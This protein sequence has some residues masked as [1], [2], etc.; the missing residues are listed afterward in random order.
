MTILNTDSLEGLLK[1]SAIAIKPSTARKVSESAEEYRY[2]KV[3]GSYVGKWRNSFAPYLTEVMDELG[4]TT[5]DAVI[6]A[7]PARCGKSDIFFNYLTHIQKSDPSDFMV[8]HMTKTTARDW[9]LG[10]LRK[11]FRVTS[12]LGAMVMP[13]RQNMN[14]HDIN[15][16]GGTRLL[17]KWPTIAELS[18]KTVPRQWLMDYDRM[19]QDIDNEGTPF[20]LTKKRGDTFSKSYRMTMAES[21]PGFEIE[22]AEDGSEW[23]PKSPHEAPPTKGILSLYNTGDMRR[24]YWRCA[25]CNEAFEGDFAHF[26][27]NKKIPNNKLASATVRLKCPNPEC[28]FEHTHDADPDNG[29]PGKSG[30]NQGGKWIKDG[31]V[32]EIDGT[33][34]GEGRQSDTASFWLKGVA[35]A[36]AKWEEILLKYLNAM[37]TYRRT[38][39]DSDLKTTVNVDQGHPYNRKNLNAGLSADTVAR[40]QRTFYMGEVPQNVRFLVAGV[41]VQADRFDVLVS[42]FDDLGNLYAIDRFQIKISKRLSDEI[43]DQFERIEP[44]KYPEDWQMLVSEVIE[45]RY[46]IEGEQDRFM[47]I[48]MVACDSGGKDGFTVNAYAFWLSLRDDPHSRGYHKKFQLVKGASNHDAPQ[49]R[50]TYPNSERKDRK[51]RARGE[52]P[53]GMIGTNIQKDAVFGMLGKETGDGR[54][55]IPEGFPK[56][57]IK[58]CFAEVRLSTGKWDNPKRMRNETFDCLVYCISILHHR[59]IRYFNIDWDDVVPPWVHELV[60]ERNEDGEFELSQT[61]DDADNLKP[62]TLAALGAALA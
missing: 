30:L 23:E 27:W 59:R 28:G 29:Q 11:A 55:H 7:G 26:V 9:S 24:F 19:D 8:V 43:E 46:P 17:V 44:D 62:R 5:K 56:W 3:P 33:V 49:F 20:A 14:V 60:F 48:H 41:D 31:Q 37:D 13:G 21:S 2:I 40:R 10:D 15:F 39:S 4:S 32:W 45:K 57:A 36:F 38:Q 54:I 22:T 12:A 61:T 50:V 16:I 47:G 53:V 58:E 52:I 1:K 51:A 6:F 25:G 34:S 35:A 42:G 18:G